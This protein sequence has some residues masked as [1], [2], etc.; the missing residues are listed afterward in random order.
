MACIK[1]WSE[2]LEATRQLTEKKYCHNE[3][4]RFVL[5]WTWNLLSFHFIVWELVK[6]YQYLEFEQIYETLNS[7]MEALTQHRKLQT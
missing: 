2:T 1:L 7:L 3:G 6:K 5:L 4:L